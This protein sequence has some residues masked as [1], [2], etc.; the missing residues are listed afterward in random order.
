MALKLYDKIMP[1]GNFAL[2]ASADVEMSDGTRLE[3][4]LA[5][6]TIEIDY[7]E[8]LA[9]D[10]EEIVVD[11]DIGGGDQ[12]DNPPDEPDEPDEPEEDTDAKP[13]LGTG[14]LGQIILA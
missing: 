4:F 3:E 10:T 8:K 1:S 11:F 2:V 13:I 14:K 7:D 6:L 5:A 12:P 9:F